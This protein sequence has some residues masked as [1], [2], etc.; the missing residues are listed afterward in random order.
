VIVER[1]GTGAGRAVP[2][3]GQLMQFYLGL[4]D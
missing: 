1:A 4:D 3:A 2:M